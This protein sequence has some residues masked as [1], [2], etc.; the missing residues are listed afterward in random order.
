MPVGDDKLSAEEIELIRRWIDAGARS[1]GEQIGGD[2]LL[3]GSPGVTGRDVVVTILQV[4]CVLCHGRRNQEG[5]LDLRTRASLLKG[6]N[7]G[8]AIV[9]GKP[10]ESL[11]IKRIAD[12]QMPPPESLRD[13][14]VR[15]VTSAELEQLRIWIRAGAPAGP[16]EVKDVGSGPDSLVREKDRQFWSFQSPR[17]PPVP[18][19]KS[20]DSVRTPI[21]SFLLEK[22]EANGLGFAPETERLALMRRAYFD[23]IGLPPES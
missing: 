4:R 6:G 11:L 10:D 16:A 3:A 17:R 14:T 19:V 5:G 18:N 8:P 21:D 1:E 15:P 22:L 7:S 13:F 23:L 9:L 12:H 2:H 20:Q